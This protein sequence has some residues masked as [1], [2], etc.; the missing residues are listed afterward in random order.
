MEKQPC[1]YILA[2]GRAGTL[3][4]GVTSDLLGRL[5]KHR[6]GITQGFAARYGAL[7]LVWY[8]MHGD[9]EAGVQHPDPDVAFV[10]GMVAHHRAAI[11]MAQIQLRHGS[12]PANRKL[13]QEIIQTQQREIE[14]MT[15]WLQR[16]RAAT[17]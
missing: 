17:N 14:E 4:I 2:S 1:V 8:E 9:M 16:H 15:A 7:K 13:A 6:E 5:Y 12:D 11:E 3:Y 10:R